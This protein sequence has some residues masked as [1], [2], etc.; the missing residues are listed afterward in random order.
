MPLIIIS[1]VTSLNTSYYIAFTLVFKKT[2][3]ACKWLFQYIENLYEYLDIPNL[4]FI[5]T[6]THN[7]LI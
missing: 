1:G 4:S 6:N 7:S 5:L 2:F 3:E